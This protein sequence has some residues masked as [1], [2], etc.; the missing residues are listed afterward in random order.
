MP[1]SQFPLSP[2]AARSAASA[3]SENA[4]RAWFK[5]KRYL[6]GGPLAFF[7]LVGFIGSLG[8]DDTEPGGTTAAMVALE[9]TQS[10]EDI[11]A[12]EAEAT[13]QAEKD[14]A[15]AATQAQQDAADAAAK[16]EQDAADAAA[17]AAEE[18]AA[19]E[20][21]AAAAAA[22]LAARGTVSQQNALRSA[23]SYI[24]Y[25]AFSYSGLIGQLEFEG[26]STEDATWGTDRANIDWNEQAS[27]SA[28]SYLDYS[29][30]SRS[31]LVDQLV[32]EGFT[33]EQAEYGV[34]QTGL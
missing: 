15:D 1:H 28:S 7:V 24:D 29:S 6:I 3:P 11:A 10:P 22:D 17:K 23:M 34:G 5:K 25:S 21:A 30:F 9:E 18:A 12:A 14:A 31:G 4:R 8:G 2:A 20:A 19:A 13:A 27:K 26:F 16:A 33:P 32:F